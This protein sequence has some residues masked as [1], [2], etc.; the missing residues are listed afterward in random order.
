M[1]SFL[2]KKICVNLRIQN[3][4]NCSGASRNQIFPITAPAACS[5]PMA[6]MMA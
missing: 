4:L 1:L 5:L 2:I 3:V 6:V